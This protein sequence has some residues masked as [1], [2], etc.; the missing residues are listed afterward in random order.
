MVTFVAFYHRM[1]SSSRMNSITSVDHKSADSAVHETTV[2]AVDKLCMWQLYK[3]NYLIPLNPSM[4]TLD[5]AFSFFFPLINRA[6]KG[7]LY[8]NWTIYLL[9]LF[10]V[11]IHCYRIVNN[12]RLCRKKSN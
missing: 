12:L 2:N 10:A 11:H 7:L 5:S 9:P 1:L 3:K 8:K 4:Y 6:Q